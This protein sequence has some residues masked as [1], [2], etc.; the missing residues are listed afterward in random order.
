M[1]PRILE[2]CVCIL[3]FQLLPFFPSSSGSSDD[4]RLSRIMFFFKVQNLLLLCHHGF[5]VRSYPFPILKRALNKSRALPNWPPAFLGKNLPHST[6]TKAIFYLFY[7]S[8]P[9]N[10]TFIITMLSA[11]NFF[12]S[13]YQISKS[14]F[15]SLFSAYLLLITFWALKPP[16]SEF[17]FIFIVFL[18][19]R[20]KP[21]VPWTTTASALSS[22]WWRRRSATWRNC[23]RSTPAP[24]PRRSRSS[25]IRRWKDSRGSRSSSI[26]WRRE[27]YEWSLG[28]KLYYQH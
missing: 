12:F 20:P 4:G 27:R 24:T 17:E 11:L 8:S 26:A 6:F 2:A 18:L 9:S 16:I 3:L 13:P 15:V 22:W 21:F 1:F 7:S 5:D 19:C 14:S 25:W 23:G 10:V 28:Q